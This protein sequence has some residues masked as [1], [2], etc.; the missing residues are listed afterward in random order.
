MDEPNFEIR[1]PTLT[2]NESFSFRVPVFPADESIDI[3]EAAF[4]NN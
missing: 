3:A 2:K 1:S 4:A